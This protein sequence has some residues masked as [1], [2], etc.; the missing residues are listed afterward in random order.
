MDEQIFDGMFFSQLH[1]HSNDL[2]LFL[3]GN[4]TNE[5]VFELCMWTQEGYQNTYA[6]R[7][8]NISLYYRLIN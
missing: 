2:D 3:F 4:C 7:F 5:L 6:V 8:V 1:F